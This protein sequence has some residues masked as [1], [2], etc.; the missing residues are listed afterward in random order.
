M[1]KKAVDQVATY[2]TGFVSTLL[3]AIIC[4]CVLFIFT[5]PTIITFCCLALA[6]ATGLIVGHC[7]AKR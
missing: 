3:V 1:V 4:F 5:N 6:H 7:L 2:S